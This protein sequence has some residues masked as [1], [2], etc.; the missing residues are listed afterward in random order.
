MSEQIIWN[1]FRSIGLSEAGTAGLMGNLYCESLLKSNNVEDR[2]SLS[3][4]D[5]TYN[6]DNGIMSRQA[7]CFDAYGYGLAQ[8]TYNTRKAGLYDLAKSKKVSISDEAMQ[9][10][11]CTNELR[12]EYPSLLSFLCTTTDVYTAAS[13]VCTEYERPA[14]NNISQRAN[15][16]NE[17]YNKYSGSAIGE[18]TSY[19]P[20][21]R[22]NNY[23]TT[24][25]GSMWVP[26]TA[27]STQMCKI[28]MRC[29]KVGDTGDDVYALQCM[30]N[31]KGTISCGNPDGK[32]G[33]NTLA[34]LN[35][36][37]T[38]LGMTLD[39]E[40]TATEDLLQYLYS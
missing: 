11:F 10:E 24:A 34:A 35:A 26:S 14:V 30:L 12:N 33:G 18:S 2:C 8:W 22:Q 38:Q 39:A 16:A 3:D 31:R 23:S 9:C 15:K 19:T 17:Y 5:Y 25:T 6:V 40:G 7:F 27:Q 28:E 20:T 29:C 37:K 1:T 36:V 32:Y 4:S 21:V 13:R